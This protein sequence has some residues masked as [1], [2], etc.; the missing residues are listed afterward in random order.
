MEMTFE[1][2]V[3]SVKDRYET[4]TGSNFFED[5]GNHSL[6][7]IRKDFENSTGIDASIEK[8]LKKKSSGCVCE[9][10]HA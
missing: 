8:F 4:K 7:D 3:C 2:Y 9:A 5:F 1:V 10:G 6:E